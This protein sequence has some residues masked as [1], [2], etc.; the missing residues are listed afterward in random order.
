M[1]IEGT[2]LNQRD[3]SIF[4]TLLS[5]AHS[6]NHSLFLVLPFYLFQVATEFGTTTETIGLVA[7]ISG[8]IYGAGSLLGGSLSDR[9]GEI[10]TITLSLAFA[11]SSTLIFIVAHDLSTF[12][13]ALLLVG[14]GASLYHPTANSIISKVFQ[15]NMAET[16][17]IHGTGGNVGYM[18]AP[19]V[20]V[21]LGDLWGWRYPWILFGLLS[22]IVS[23]LILKTSR[24]SFKKNEVKVR[25]RDVVKVQGLLILLAFNM[26]AGLY[27][28]GVDFIFP[29]F[30]E[31][32]FKPLFSKEVVSTLKGSVV[33]GILA[34]GILGQWLGGKASDKFG[35]KKALIIT[36]VFVS[37]SLF[38]LPTVP[39][40]FVSLLLFVPLYGFFFYAHQPA[41][42]S[43]AGLITPNDMRGTMYGIL[44]FFSFGLGSASTAI[45]TSLAQ[46]YNLNIAF[47]ALMMFSLAALLLSFFAPSKR[48]EHT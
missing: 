48:S 13:V 34:V 47:Y 11:G 37:I 1:N 6:L 5:A 8:F 30:V 9:L 23:L 27:F 2:V 18:F 10:K 24:V 45:T 22:I 26:L 41:L 38:L 29:S 35:S 15:T 20:T 36:S 32:R 43:L 4:L 16:M 42:N 31:D 19:L 14:A 12:S 3:K 33:F 44:F 17:G 28:K 21:A 7:A 25:M 39:E 40:T 46:R